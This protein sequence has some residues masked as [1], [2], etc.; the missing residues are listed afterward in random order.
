MVFK[1]YINNLSGFMYKNF[2]FRSVTGFCY[3]TKVDKKILG[4]QRVNENV[5]KT[6]FNYS[7]FWNLHG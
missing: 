3:L 2:A 7:F 1:V 4:T 6:S 5:N